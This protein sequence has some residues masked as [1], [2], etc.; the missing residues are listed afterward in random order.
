MY[1]KKLCGHNFD[2]DCECAANILSG[3]EM[4]EMMYKTTRLFSESR[5]I[6]ELIFN[7]E[8][9]KYVRED[10]KYVRYIYAYTDIVLRGGKSFTSSC[11]RSD[12][13]LIGAAG[14]ARTLFEIGINTMYIR[15][16]KSEH[17]QQFI[18]NAA[19][20]FE[21]GTNLFWKF[22]EK[23]NEEIPEKY[24]KSKEGLEK[25]KQIYGEP[26]LSNQWS[27]RGV[28]GRADEVGMKKV[29]AFLYPQ[30]SSI[31][32]ASSIQM[33]AYLASGE[34]ATSNNTVKFHSAPDIFSD[35]F[36]YYPA[37]MIVLWSVD[38]MT[39]EFIKVFEI[40]Y[41]E[42]MDYRRIRSSTNEVVEE[43]FELCE[44]SVEEESNCSVT[45]EQ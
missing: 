25:L 33:F 32:H 29:C 30:L 8:N 19:G 44:F 43:F 31:T 36:F 14:A 22:R 16:N 7:L 3:S 23:E 24:I 28:S 17:L 27:G 11:A 40:P 26:R 13:G 1:N 15:E 42:T 18:A 34:S 5:K 12:I 39:S 4:Q 37:W 35:F 6:F 2:E 38:L 20:T 45:K 9:P 21:K 10:S 41:R